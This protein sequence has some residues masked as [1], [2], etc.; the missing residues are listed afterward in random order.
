MAQKLVYVDDLS[1][2]EG[3]DSI[4]PCKFSYEGVEFK[5]DFGDDSRQKLAEALAPFMEVAQR[6]ASGTR[7]PEEL[8]PHVGHSPATHTSS[9][10]KKSRGAPSHVG[11]GARTHTPEEVAE[12]K[13]WL[14]RIG[15]AEPWARIPDDIWE[16]FRTGDLGKLKEGR[17]PVYDDEHEP[18]QQAQA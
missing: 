8:R 16:A 4:R 13:I 11:E 12:L 7:I 17:L 6:V 1:G 2:E 18:E 15:V 5:A 3:D 10:K 14:K 9:S